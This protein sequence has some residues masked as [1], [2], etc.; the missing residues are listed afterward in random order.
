MWIGE[1][2]AFETSDFVIIDNKL[3]HVDSNRI[4]KVQ[5]WTGKNIWSIFSKNRITYS[6]GDYCKYSRRIVNTS[7]N[8]FVLIEN[9]H[10]YRID[11]NTGVQELVKCTQQNPIAITTAGDDLLVLTSDGSISEINAQ[12]LEESRHFE[13]GYKLKKSTDEVPIYYNIQS[14]GSK[15]L[16]IDNEWPESNTFLYD[17]KSKTGIKYD[18]QDTFVINSSLVFEDDKQIR[19]VDPETM[20]TLWWIDRKDITGSN[21]QVAWCDWR[22]VCVISDDTI[23]CYAPPK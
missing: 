23:S 1:Q 7:K 14:I 10:S 8:L 18:K 22:G 6:L 16:I 20:E 5:P 15:I 13:T 9:G 2:L 21:S 17:T 4:I 19:G 12:T 11:L 3:F